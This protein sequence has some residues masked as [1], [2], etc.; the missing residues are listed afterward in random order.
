MSVFLALIVT[1]QLQRKLN[2]HPF[3]TFFQNYKYANNFLF[4]KDYHAGRNHISLS[5]SIENF[6]RKTLYVLVKLALVSLFVLNLLEY[7]D[8]A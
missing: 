1:I 5:S 8:K 4:L 3:M 2:V 6:E 7:V